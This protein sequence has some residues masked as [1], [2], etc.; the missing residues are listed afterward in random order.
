[1]IENV[2]PRQYKS[3][4]AEFDE[5]LSKF[6]ETLDPTWDAIRAVKAKKASSL[7]DVVVKIRKGLS[8]K[9]CV[10]YSVMNNIAFT[11]RVITA[12]RGLPVREEAEDY[13]AL[14][15]SGKNVKMGREIVKYLDPIYR[16]CNDSLL[17]FKHR[18]T[19]KEGDLSGKHQQKL[20][21]FR[22]NVEYLVAI[23]GI[24][25]LSPTRFLRLKKSLLRQHF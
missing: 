17:P 7:E 24:N 25:P 2:F 20:E 14:L 4:K 15:H 16:H 13:Y 6:Y 9:S 21:K 11:M 12:N 22:N 19:S 1:M 18:L 3:K 5:H 23:C 8:L 10:E